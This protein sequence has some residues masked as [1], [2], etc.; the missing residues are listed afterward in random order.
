MASPINE[1][2]KYHAKRFNFLL[3]SIKKAV[4]NFEAKI[5][6]VGRSPFSNILH[7]QYKNLTTLG[8]PLDQ[9][10]IS[11]LESVER[12]IPHVVFD[13]SQSASKDQWLKASPYDA[14]VFAEVIEHLYVAPEHALA[15]LAS[16]LKTGGI[17]I[18]QTP[19]AAAI[20]N[21]IKLLM[22]KNPYN[23]IALDGSEPAH[24]REYTKDELIE[25]FEKSGFEIIEQ[26]FINYFG[27]ENP[28]VGIIDKVTDWWPAFRRGQT[29]VAKKK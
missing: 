16:L 11:K 25:M 18:C 9:G 27:Y 1:Y 4:P 28:I 2:A 22:G 23:R 13:L 6:E 19:N 5:L 24:F 12:S 7:S 15:F 20:H 3:S 17:I 21:R 29:L 10:Y 8:F 26:S 14:V